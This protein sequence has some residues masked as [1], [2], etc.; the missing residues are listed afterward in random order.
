MS[1]KV[2]ATLFETGSESKSDNGSK[3]EELTLSKCFRLTPEN[4]H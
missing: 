3:G 4:G 2:P 1:C